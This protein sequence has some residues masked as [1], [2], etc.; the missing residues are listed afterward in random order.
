MPASKSSSAPKAAAVRS[1]AP[2]AAARLYSLALFGPRAA[3]LDRGDIALSPGDKLPRGVA[4]IA[5]VASYCGKP[6]TMT[7]RGEARTIVG[8]RGMKEVAFAGVG[9]RLVSHCD[10]PDWAWW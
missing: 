10:V 7:D 1:V 8:W 9:T 5:S 3:G 2:V 4:T 6:F